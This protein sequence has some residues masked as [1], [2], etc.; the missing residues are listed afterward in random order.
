MARAYEP[1][2]K[3]IF[4]PSWVH[5]QRYGKL[6]GETYIEKYLDDIKQMF[7]YGEVSSSNKMNAS[8]MCEQLMLKYLNM[9][10]LPG[11]IE[12]KKSIGA[13]AQKQQGAQKR[14]VTT[15]MRDLNLNGRRI[16]KKW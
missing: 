9:F 14:T 16:L 8:K 4:P 10:S 2:E 12:I 6:Y 15:R 1:C 3:E 5:R 11:E 13:F 7:Q